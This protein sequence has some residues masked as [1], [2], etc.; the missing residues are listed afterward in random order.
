MITEFRAKNYGCL[1]DIVLELTP[2]HALIGPNDSGK[3]TILR[4]IDTLGQLAREGFQRNATIGHWHPFD[5]G[6]PIEASQ[7]RDLPLEL[8]ST[9]QGFPGG[10]QLD[11]SGYAFWAGAND[12]HQRRQTAGPWSGSVPGWWQES[13]V[14]LP[15]LL[16]RFE[17]DALRYASALIPHD[18]AVLFLD[19]RGRGLPGVLQSI[20]GR[21]YDAFQRINDDV[22]SLFPT[23]RYVQVVARSASELVVEAELTDGTRVPAA[24]VSE[25][26]LYYL[27]FASIPYLAPSSILL[28]EEPENGLHPSRI[29]TV[30][31]MLR[32][33]GNKSGTQVILATHSP[34]VVNELRPEE[35]T[36]VTRPSVETGSVVTPMT[37]TRN[38]EK[39]RSAYSLG[40]LWLAYADGNLESD[41][42]DTS[43]Q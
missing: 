17:A 6:L 28:V 22:R 26:L 10:V 1:R 18:R 19:Q 30:I 27:A 42:V 31:K 40:E 35:V 29:A 14:N 7:A 2:F 36:I 39:R 11:G 21:Y 25:G 5:P 33:F 32:E 4:G 43:E 16:A 8:A 23:I 41:L 38:F 24:Q 15:A 20:Q 3:S 37:K 12:A 34:L 9:S 13:M